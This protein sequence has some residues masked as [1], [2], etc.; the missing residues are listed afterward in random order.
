MKASTG[1]GE[2]TTPLTTAFVHE[3]AE[4]KTYFLSGRP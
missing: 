3:V 1:G 4:G 2:G